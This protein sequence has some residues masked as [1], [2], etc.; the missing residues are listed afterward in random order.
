MTFGSPRVA[1]RKFKRAFHALVG[2]SLR[3]TYGGDP[4]PS[5]PPSFRSAPCILLITLIGSKSSGC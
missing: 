5:I 2:T 1:N 3:L 4:V